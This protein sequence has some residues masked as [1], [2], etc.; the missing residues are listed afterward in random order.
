M[1]TRRTTKDAKHAELENVGIDPKRLS[2]AFAEVDEQGDGELELFEFREFWG[3]VF[4]DRPM[5]EATWKY[6][7][8]MFRE[9]DIDCS[10]CISFEEIVSFLN[11]S[12]DV[13]RERARRPKTFFDWCYIFCTDSMHFWGDNAGF[14]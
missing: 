14:I 8:S 9:I 12:L 11:K 4:P 2:A 13:E 5:T 6:T 3:M 7:E 10:N 1:T